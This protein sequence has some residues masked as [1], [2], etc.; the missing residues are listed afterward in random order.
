MRREEM[1]NWPDAELGN[2][3]LSAIRYALPRQ[4]GIIKDHIAFTRR[5]WYDI[6]PYW[7]ALILRDCAEPLDR[8]DRDIDMG[9]VDSLCVEDVRQFVEWITRQ[10]P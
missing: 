9:G 7:H 1:N 2:I 3:V 6:T 5:H 8:V 4:T 10:T